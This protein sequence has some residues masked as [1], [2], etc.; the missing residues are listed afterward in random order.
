MA[1]NMEFS[2]TRFVSIQGST[3][4][5]SANSVAE[6]R[7]AV[8]ELRLKKKEYRLLKRSIAQA[9]KAIRAAYTREVRTR[10]SMARGG[11]TLG[12]VVRAF[13]TVSRDGQRSQLAAELAPR[14]EQMSQAEEMIQTLDSAI[15]Q[16]E[17]QLLGK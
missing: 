16:V 3:V 12:M 7:S 9:M 17:A 13:Q 11:G 10:G 6:A 2:A 1:A 4:R 5:V 15:M 14:E 8:K